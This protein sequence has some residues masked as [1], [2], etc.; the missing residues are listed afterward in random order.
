MSRIHLTL[1][2]VI[3][4]VLLASCGGGGGGGSSSSDDSTPVSDTTAPYV[5]STNPL[6]DSTNEAVNRNITVTFNEEM[7]AATIT[8]TS[9]LVDN[10]TTSAVVSGTITYDAASKTATFSSDSNLAT[11]TTYE[12]TITTD[13]TD[14][15]GNALGSDYSWQFTTAPP[16]AIDATSPTVLSYSPAAAATSVATNTVIA[17]TFSEALNPETINTSTITVAGTGAVAGEVTLV[18][19]TVMFVPDTDLDTDTVY[20]VTVAGTIEDLAGNTLGTDET[21]SFTTGSQADLDSPQLLSVSPANGET[22][23]ATDTAIVV[24]FNEAIKPFNFGIIDGNP[25]IVSFNDTYTTIT[26]QPT[27]GL[28]ANA[29][30]SVSV[31]VADQA[32][33]L[34]EEALTWTFTT[35]P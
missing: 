19:T 3:F 33:N 27:A 30:Y 28:T 34:M 7:D 32:G 1:M 10:D 5:L 13:V 8:E 14:E 12:V 22:G 17:V 9:F 23:V 4:T 25:V 26:L 18:G 20:S 6:Y 24:T 31:Q 2:S 29:I 11:N 21:W 15:A 35:A 16:T